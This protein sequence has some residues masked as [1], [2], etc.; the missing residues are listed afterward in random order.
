MFGG[1]LNV[2]RLYGEVIG[3]RRHAEALDRV[4]ELGLFHVNS[5]LP[6]G[7]RTYRESKHPY[8]DDHFFVSESLRGAIEDVAVLI[9]SR[10]AA[11]SD[12]YPLLLELRL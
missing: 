9:G 1:D 12:H 5:L 4:E 11:S 8:Q 7:A 10:T 2:D 3:T 6:Q